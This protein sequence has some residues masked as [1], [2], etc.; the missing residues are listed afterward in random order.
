LNYAQKACVAAVH[1]AKV[2]SENFPNGEQ[3]GDM[4]MAQ[5]ASKP[6]TK[7]QLVATLAEEMGS[8]KKTANAALDALSAIVS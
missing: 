5:A 6:M 7:T 3:R 2:A 1:A 8:D 4:N